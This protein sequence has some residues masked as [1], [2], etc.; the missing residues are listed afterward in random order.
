MDAKQ[1]LEERPFVREFEYGANIEGY[2]S[3]KH[4]VFKWKIAL[5]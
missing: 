3:Y 1:P 2:W 4:M 5:M